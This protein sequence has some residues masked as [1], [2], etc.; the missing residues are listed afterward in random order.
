MAI[1][2]DLLIRHQLY[3]DR[4]A[5]EGINTHLYPSL[6]AAY[7]EIRRNLLDSELN[8]TGKLKALE[9]QV[10]MSILTHDGWKPLTEDM[11]AVGINESEFHATALAAMTTATIKRPAEKQIESFLSSAMMSLEQGKRSKTALW[12]DY[13]IA[14]QNSQ[15]EQIN[16]IIRQAYIRG[17]GTGKAARDIKNLFNDVLSQDAETLARTGYSHYQA[18][19]QEAMAKA[20]DIDMEYYY[21]AVMDNRTTLGCAGLDGKRWPLDSPAVVRTPRH[22]NCRSTLLTV[23]TGEDVTGT[24]VAVGAKDTQDARD[25]FDKRDASG[26]KVKRRGLKDDDVFKPQQIKATTS[27]DEFLKRQ[28]DYFIE[29]SLGPTRAKLF[30]DGGLSIEKFTDMR[31]NPLTLAELRVKDAEAFKRAGL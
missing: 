30:T 29:D 22:F 18:A 25:K 16:S 23:P 9:K 3:L 13:V 17:E 27:Y 24:R 1:D 26:K 15:T 2:L 14:S 19:A 31:G 10:R 8:T 12:A 4:K 11:L 21:S 5:S 20:Q 7:L 28:P 6:R